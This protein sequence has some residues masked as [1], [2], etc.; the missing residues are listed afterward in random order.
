MLIAFTGKKGHGKD[1]AAQVL[2]ERGFTQVRFASPLKEMLRTL[3][4]YQGLD[5]ETIHRMI[6][7]DL[8]EQPCEYLRGQSPRHAMVTLGTEWGRDLIGGDLWCETFAYAIEAFDN[9]VCTDLRFLNE[10]EVI[11]RYEG[12]IIRIVNPWVS[13]D[14]GDNHSSETEQD[15]ICPDVT[16]VNDQDIETL[17]RRVLKYLKQEGIVE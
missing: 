3:L 11:R 6:E 7:G 5:E 2:I 1:T 15:Y 16:I 12:V 10:E 4:R 8:K 13:T 9:V 17:H 14:P